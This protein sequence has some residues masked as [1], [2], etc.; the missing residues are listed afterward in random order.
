MSWHAEKK[1]HILTS[2]DLHRTDEG[3]RKEKKKETH[4][5][6]SHADNDKSKSNSDVC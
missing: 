4:T 6:Q 5:N 3:K 2:G 1:Q